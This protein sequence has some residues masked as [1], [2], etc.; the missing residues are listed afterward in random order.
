MVTLFW[1]SVVP[2]QHA[3]KS[4]QGQERADITDT[5]RIPADAPHTRQAI[6]LA[7][8][9]ATL[10]PS[11]RTLRQRTYLEKEISQRLVLAEAL[12]SIVRLRF[13]GVGRAGP[14]CAHGQS[15]RQAVL[16]ILDLPLANLHNNDIF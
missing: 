5:Q 11:R 2:K 7:G 6:Q 3:L 12:F 15:G 10:P 8:N 13:P 16:P 1:Q 14:P 4:S 9:Q